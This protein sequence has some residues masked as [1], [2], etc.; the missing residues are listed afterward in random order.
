VLIIPFV[1]QIVGAVGLVGYLSFR[2][3]QKAVEDM[4]KPLMAEIGDRIDQNLN[5]HL[6]K[7]KELTRNNAAVIKL[8]FLNYQD[9]P[10]VERYLWEQSQIFDKLNALVVATETKDMLVI[11]KLDDGSRVVRIRT[12]LNNY[13]WNNY[14]TDS[15]GNHTKLIEDSQ[16]DD[17]PQKSPPE[18]RPWYEVG[19]KTP[20]GT[21]QIVVSRIKLDEPRLVAAYVLPF[22][23]RN[24]TLQGVVSC[25]ISLFQLGDF[26][27]SLKIGK[28]GQAFILENNGFLIGT[29]T[30]ETPFVPSLVNSL[31][32]DIQKDD[33]NQYRLN[34]VNS[35]EELTRQTTKKLLEYF[36]RLDRIK[37]KQ[38][39][40]F[41]DNGQRYFAQ[42]VPFQG[43]KD[44]NWLTVIVIPEND[45]IA[46]I[47][48]NASW[49]I[50][51]C[52][53]TLVVATGI[54]ILTARWIT[55]PIL[56]LNQATQAIA[57]GKWQESGIQEGLTIVE[58]QGIAEVTNLAD[59]FNS[60]ALQLQTSFETLE[61][62]VEER[63]AELVIAKEKAEV[64]NEAKS[65][66]IANMSHELRSPL[67]A[68]LGF[69]QLMLRATNLR[70][71]HYENV[72]IIYR[73]GE[74]LLTLINNVLDL[75]KIEAGKTTLNPTDFD[76][77]R[78]LYDLE[79]MLHL[80]ASNQG[81]NLI[82]QRSENV[83]RYICTDEVKLRQVLIN[84][85]SNSI[86]FTQSGGISLTVN[87]SSEEITDILTLDFSVHDTGIGI[88]T[89]ELPKLFEAFS[90]TQSGKDSQEGTGL[91]LVIS[92]KFVQL[93]EGDI[94]VE[95][96]LGKGTTFKFSI[97][98]K[99]GQQANSNLVE[100]HPQVLE[101]VP[102][103]PTYKLL[104]VDDKAINRQLLIK[105]LQPLGFEIK[106][107]SNGKEAITI[108]E[109]WEP[110]LIFMDM[111]MPIMDGYEATKHIKST[112]KGNAT[113]VIA[114]TASVLEEEKAIV[115]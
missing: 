95:S 106:E 10:A 60:M 93:M 45:F 99:L 36:G 83:P 108:W 42:V 3:G 52:C 17:H 70:T 87:N 25:S 96:E 78:L 21:W 71:D 32:S 80:R 4:V 56:R 104:T 66:F 7:P 86:K 50:V 74:Y 15:Q 2:S 109:E 55:N 34:A 76:L 40:S 81:L 91:G 82:F 12:K 24:N 111:R 97:Q 92:R 69:S 73:S 46:E 105:L 115:L 67:N 30:G 23:D 84:L 58:V 57:E 85:I 68:I 43:Q 1:L 13:K 103:Q 88:S 18:N 29:S 110:H 19:K 48:A 26:L 14:L 100:E 20:S 101:L 38:K 49:T 33:P 39:F 53:L 11:N 9:F 54:G 107:A 113:A 28:T 64:A 98:A 41:T 112:T 5:N 90:Q 37:T 114:L 47:Q 16:K 79:D 59:S 75:S 61:N 94:S 35:R 65:T 44:L 102:G 27:K 8:G 22:F 51:F 77:Y 6:Q 89:A 62:R 63:T 72:G 31:K